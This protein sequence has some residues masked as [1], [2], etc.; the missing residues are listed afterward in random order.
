MTTDSLRIRAEGSLEVVESVVAR[1]RD[2][3]RRL[4]ENE[5]IDVTGFFVKSAELDTALSVVWPLLREVDSAEG[6]EVLAELDQAREALANS[7]TKRAARDGLPLRPG[8]LTSLMEQ[9]RAHLP[10]LHR[11]GVTLRAQY[12]MLWPTALSG[13]GGLALFVAGQHLPGAATLAL[14]V[15]FQRWGPQRRNLLVARS[16]IFLGNEEFALSDLFQVTVEPSGSAQVLVL[17][18]R[19]GVR[20]T[21]VVDD[22][23][24]ALLRVLQRLGVELEPQSVV[25]AALAKRRVE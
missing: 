12:P 10:A 9:L 6:S 11:A 7:A 23:K 24:H 22:P 2:L 19:A 25:E 13:L 21:L 18:V 1:Y 3:S 14:A 5:P 4:D 16:S 20:R 8:S 15:M 17:W